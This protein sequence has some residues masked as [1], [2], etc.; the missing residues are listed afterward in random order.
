MY[1]CTLILFYAIGQV[2]FVCSKLCLILNILVSIIK[3]SL[4]TDS[5]SFTF[6]LAGANKSSS[7]LPAEPPRLL[8][9][10]SRVK[11]TTVMSA[12][13]L[14]DVKL[15]TFKHDQCDLDAVLSKPMSN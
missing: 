12:A 14:P 15:V 8:L 11:F 3:K 13:I 10:S 6:L 7:N 9:V 5:L 2:V 4:F 1:A